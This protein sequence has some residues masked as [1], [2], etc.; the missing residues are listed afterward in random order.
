MSSDDEGA[1][2]EDLTEVAKPV[3]KGTKKTQSRDGEVEVEA[4]NADDK[5]DEVE[6]IEAPE[7]DAEAQLSK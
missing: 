7:E 5:A 6:E 2:D 1:D 3:R 4:S